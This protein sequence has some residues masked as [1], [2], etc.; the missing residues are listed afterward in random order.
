[1]EW[2]FIAPMIMGVV[3]ML[4]V[5]GVLVLRP[6]SKRFAELLESYAQDRQRGVGSDIHQIRELMETMDGRLRLMEERQDCP[7]KLLQSGHRQSTEGER[8]EGG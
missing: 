5:G 3:F 2:E 4:T 8:P 7:E 1:M 6:L